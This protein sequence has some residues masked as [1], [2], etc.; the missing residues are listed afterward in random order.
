[1]YCLSE[2]DGGRMWF[3]CVDS[4]TERCTY[5][6]EFTTHSDLTVVSTGELQ[7][8]VNIFPLYH[9]IINNLMVCA[10]FITG[11]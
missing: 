7:K 1:M 10:A 2:V 4:L 3:P 11:L 6:M 8:Q 5:T 9:H